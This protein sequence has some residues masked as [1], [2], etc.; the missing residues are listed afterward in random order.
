MNYALQHP[1]DKARVDIRLQ[2]QRVR[3]SPQDGMWLDQADGEFGQTASHAGD[4]FLA[5]LAMHDDLPI[6]ES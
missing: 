6:S 3:K 2:S 1:L 5:G 4:R